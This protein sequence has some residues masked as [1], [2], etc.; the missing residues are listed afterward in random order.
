MLAGWR[1]HT[2]EQKAKRL[3]CA[4]EAEIEFAV[5]AT[6]RQLTTVGRVGIVL[7][8]GSFAT[9]SVQILGSNA[10]QLTAHAMRLTQSLH[11]MLHGLPSTVHR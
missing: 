2:L 4:A 9:V 8:L 10:S 6:A 5:A 7:A 11:S 3:R 1:E